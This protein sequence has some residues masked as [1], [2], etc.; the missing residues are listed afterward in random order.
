[1]PIRPRLFAFAVILIASTLVAHADTVEFT[2][3]PADGASGVDSF[4]FTAP[5]SPTTLPEPGQGPNSFIL[6]PNELQ[7]TFDNGPFPTGA[8]F[9]LTGLILG[10]DQ[11]IT[12]GAPIYTLKGGDPSMPTFS[13]GTFD[14][15]QE[16]DANGLVGE[17]TLT[18]TDLSTIGLG[19]S[20]TPTPEPSTL[21]LFGTGI[22]GLVG[23]ARR[24]F[25]DRL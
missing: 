17:G 21:A 16:F 11:F 18:I 9:E 24:K 25:L 13:T 2:F 19:P 22:L 14:G 1:M 15:I 10:S 8:I 3:T 23:A 5:A 4:S 6:F 12:G 20:P 7:G